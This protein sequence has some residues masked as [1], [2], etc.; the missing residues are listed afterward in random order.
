M[1]V[2]VLRCNA[3]NYLQWSTSLSVNRMGS[4]M[5]LPALPSTCSFPMADSNWKPSASMAAS[6]EAMTWEKTLFI[7]CTLSTSWSGWVISSRWSN[8]N[9]YCKVGYYFQGVYISRISQNENFCD[10]CTWKVTT[11][12]TCMWVWFSINL[13]KINFINRRNF[14]IREILHPSKITRYTVSS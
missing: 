6:R 5:S 8:D 10:D 14:E 3:Y 1:H 11:L 2:I 7:P 12:G 4:K 9:N 13:A